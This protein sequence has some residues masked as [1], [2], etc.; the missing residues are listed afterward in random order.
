MQAFPSQVRKVFIYATEPC[1]DGNILAALSW[2]AS[3]CF[4]LS[5]EALSQTA[6]LYSSSVLIK[7]IY[8]FF[9]SI[10]IDFEF[11]VA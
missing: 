2:T 9:E 7:E 6:S 10:S 4:L 1:C 5:E 8:I 3:N 11:E